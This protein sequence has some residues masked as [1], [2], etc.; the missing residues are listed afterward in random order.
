MVTNAITALEDNPILNAGLLFT[1]FPSQM[2][3]LDRSVLE[4]LGYGS[5]L[6]LDGGIQCDAAI[7]D[8]D[9]GDFG[10]VGAVPGTVKS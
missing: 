3:G 2:T 6:S 1:I 4:C 10:S 8:G 7:M 5:N 9:S